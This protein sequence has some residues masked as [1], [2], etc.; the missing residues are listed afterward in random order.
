MELTRKK[1]LTI[2]SVFFFSVLVFFVSYNQIDFEK[3]NT[4]TMHD[5][6]KSQFSYI[7]EYDLPN[8]S[9]PNGIVVDKDGF[10][11][12]V[13]SNSRLY[14]FDPVQS[15]IDSVYV[16]G[17]DDEAKPTLMGWTIIEDNEGFLWFSQLG[18][19]PLWRFD[20]ISKRF[21]LYHVSA[22]PFQ[23]K[24]DK[25]N[26]NVWFTTL[27]RNTIGVIQK[28][29]D[30]KSDDYKI[31]EFDVGNNTFPSG[32]FLEKDYVWVAQVVGNKLTKFKINRDNN[33]LVSSIEKILEIPHENKT[34]IY[35]PTDILVTDNTI[36]FTEHGTS[37]IS[38]FNLDGN[39]VKRFPTS[40]NLF[41]TTT[42]PFWLK[43]SY[44]NNGIWINEHTGNKIAS[45]NTTD[46]SLV[47]YEIPTR[48][49]DGLIVYPLGLSITPQNSVWFSEWNTDKIGVID[50][51]KPLPFDIMANVTNITIPRT[52]EGKSIIID[53]NVFKKGNLL[54]DETR[55]I[56]LITSSSMD[57]SLR[58]VNVTAT[59]TKE[60]I[61]LTEIN[62][63]EEV[64]LL[65]NSYF[66]PSGNYTLAISATDGFVT[67]SVF[68]EMIIN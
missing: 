27:G 46:L 15:K 45:F 53:V 11:W 43:Q 22:S 5:I 19:K 36:W 65:I 52:S 29:A 39:Q 58:L 23:M 6:K 55:P 35:S 50:T 17:D 4:K 30:V 57:P 61:F 21:N 66:A 28:L 51:N 34:R 63:Q 54:I 7:K 14:K 26:G 49:T 67:K 68:I 56:S 12:V 18:S 2:A 59:F 60:K 33:G 48:P 16:I 40:L 37:T 64:Q 38:K 32:L 24:L 8:G 10:V 25:E 47:E 62:E 41:N 31:K 1:I 9:A 44:D 42:L 20:P 3:N 13:G